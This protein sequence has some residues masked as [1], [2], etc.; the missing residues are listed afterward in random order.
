MFPGLDVCDRDRSG[1]EAVEASS[2]F[3]VMV[4]DRWVEGSYGG[5]RAER[6]W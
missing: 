5:E 1:W 3:F 4:A 2:F 6:G